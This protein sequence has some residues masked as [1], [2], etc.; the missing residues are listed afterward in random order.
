MTF[1]VHVAQ[2][3]EDFAFVL[4]FYNVSLW[5]KVLQAGDISIQQNR[6]SNIWVVP[7]L[8]DAANKRKKCTSGLYLR[9]FMYR[10]SCHKIRCCL[11]VR[12]NDNTLHKNV[13]ANMLSYSR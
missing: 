7:V 4:D 3:L 11:V 10:F 6:V 9:C 13:V 1:S 5:A 8:P 12:T 2:N